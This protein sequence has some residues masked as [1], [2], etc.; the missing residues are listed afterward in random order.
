VLDGYRQAIGQPVFLNSF[1]RNEAKQ[2]QL[3]KAGFKAASK[4][5]HVVKLAADVDTPGLNE[6]IHKRGYNAVVMTPELQKEARL[7]MM[8]INYDSAITMKQ[9]AAALQIKVRI[10]HKQYLEIGQ[11]FI[12]VDV[13]PEY[14]AP[15][16]P[17]HKLG[18]PLAWEESITW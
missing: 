1:N 15:G 4:S 11:T 16:K 12:H 10:G 8:R 13:C 9:V 18:H 5:P 2:A 14:Y 17:F 3:K 6:I 7:E